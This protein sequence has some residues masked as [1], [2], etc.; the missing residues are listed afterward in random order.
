MAAGATLGAGGAGIAARSAAFIGVSAFFLA[1]FLRSFLLGRPRGGL[2]LAR[3]P[4]HEGLLLRRF[5][6]RCYLLVA[7]LR[8][9]FFLPPFFFADFF[10][11]FFF[12]A[13]LVLLLELT[14]GAA[15]ATRLSRAEHPTAERTA[16]QVEFFD[17]RRQG[18]EP[19]GKGHAAAGFS[20]VRGAADG[21]VGAGAGTAGATGAV[22]S[23]TAFFAAGFT[24]AFGF[25]TTRLT[26]RAAPAFLTFLAARRTLR[27]ETDFLTT[28]FAFARLA[29][30]FGLARAAAFFFLPAFVAM[31][32]LP[33]V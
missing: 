20:A 3:P 23:F 27:R 32:M 13:M 10:A 1:G 19:E 22:T 24:F 16:R 9:F 31:F 29:P 2:F 26:L 21:T 28:R 7:L 30:R 12:V 8:Y 6:L 4:Q 14:K 11:A 5:L 18:R 15:T 25:A 17:A 33:S